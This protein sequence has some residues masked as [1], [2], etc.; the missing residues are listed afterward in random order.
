MILIL[1]GARHQGYRCEALYQ[2]RKCEA[3][4]QGHL[5]NWLSPTVTIAESSPPGQS[6]LTGQFL[7]GVLGKNTHPCT[8]PIAPELIDLCHSSTRNFQQQFSLSS[9]YQNWLLTHKKHQLSL[10]CQEVGL[11]CLQHPHYLCP[12]LL[13]NSLIA[14]ILCVW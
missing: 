2:A 12:L 9:G 5:W 10:A 14:V 6:I 13:I 4:H 7:D 11:L 3:Q 1:C 8:H